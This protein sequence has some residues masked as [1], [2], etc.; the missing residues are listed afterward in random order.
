M[1]P[2]CNNAILVE[3]RGGEGGEDA[4]MLVREQ[5]AIYDRACKLQKL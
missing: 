4:K 1:K 3:I 2:L 5:A